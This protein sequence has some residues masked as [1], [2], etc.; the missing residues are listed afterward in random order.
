MSVFQYNYS[1]KFASLYLSTKVYLMNLREFVKELVLLLFS[2]TFIFSTVVLGYM[3]EYFSFVVS[4]A[5]LSHLFSLT[6][7]QV[8]C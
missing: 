8:D 3:S 5:Y 1:L 2:L 6:K 4:L 7:I